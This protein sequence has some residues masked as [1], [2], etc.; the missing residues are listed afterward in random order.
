MSLRGWFLIGSLVAFIWA[1]AVSWV[2]PAYFT[3]FF[4]LVPLFVLGVVDMTQKT[5]SVRRNFPVIGNL[6]YFFEFIRPELQ[7]YFVES[8][9]DGRPIPRELRSLIYQRAKGQDESVP[10][11]TQK[12]V[13]AESYDWVNHSVFTSKLPEEEL[14]YLIGGDQCKKPYSAS[15]LNI[16]AMSYGS[17]SPNAIMALNRGAQKGGFYHNTGEGGISP[18]HRQGGD[19]VWQIG[20]AYFGCRTLDGE[21]DKELFRKKSQFPEIKMIEIK[22]SQGAKPGKGGLLPAAKVSEEVAEIRNVRP[23]ETIISPASHSAFDSPDG[24]IHF[25]QHLRDLSGGKPVG[26]KLCVGKRPEFLEICRAMIRNNIYPDFITVDGSEGGTGA[27]PLEF[28]NHIGTPLNEGLHFVVETLRGFN[29]R[30]RIRVIASGRV[31]DA[32]QLLT[33]LVIG[34][35]G[36]N[37]AR[38]MM[39]ALGCIQAL[40]CHTN[41]CPVGVATTDKRFYKG[42]HIPSKA[43]RVAGFHERTLHALKAI[44]EAMGVKSI[45]NLS[46][47]NFYRRTDSENQDT[48]E[49]IFPSV[50]AGILLKSDD[51]LSPYWRE[52]FYDDDSAASDFPGSALV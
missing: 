5:H 41:H 6:R 21:F 36:V 28:T 23:H 9:L 51:K 52:F 12:D 35:D 19:L 47:R 4:V 33:K 17:L 10:F 40:R 25:V 32:F 43:D 34:A 44:I 8:D 11:G 13:Y 31:F 50:E 20:T 49:Q 7:Q 15:R 39:M 2:Q 29:I 46:K 30:D 38:G 14:R 37:S 42:L 3:V 1:G 18:Y 16:S 22:L 24:L 27:A 48:F 45:A 26:F